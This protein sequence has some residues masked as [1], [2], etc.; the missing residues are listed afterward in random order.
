MRIDLLEDLANALE[1][2]DPETDPVFQM[3]T[4]GY[5]GNDEK[6]ECLTACCAAGLGCTLPS[7]Q[8]AGLKLQRASWLFTDK[9]FD[10]VYRGEHDYIYAGINALAQVLQLPIPACERLFLPSSY[11]GHDFNRITPADV[12][13]RIRCILA[14]Q[15]TPKAQLPLPGATTDETT[16]S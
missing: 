3:K 11:F 1:Q 9:S 2:Y 13:Y 4:W 15:K 5:A 16:S 14:T 10:I 6:P 8:A 12:A 7:W